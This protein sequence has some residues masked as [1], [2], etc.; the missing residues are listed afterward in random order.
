MKPNLEHPY[1]EKYRFFSYRERNL[2]VGVTIPN[3]Y[4]R[5][6]EIAL[7]CSENLTD[8]WNEELTMGRRRTYFFKNAEDATLFALRWS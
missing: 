2:A 7:W 4:L 5:M 1:D 6:S 8:A 3:D